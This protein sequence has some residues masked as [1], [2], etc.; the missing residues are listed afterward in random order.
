MR[1]LATTGIIFL[2]SVTGA[3]AEGLY[4]GIE[5]SVVNVE[6]EDQFGGKGFVDPSA[7]NFT[8]GYELSDKVAV[9]ALFG[10]GLSSDKVENASLD[11]GFELESV[12]GLSVVG[13]YYIEEDAKFYGNL[14]FAN[15]E[16]VDSF[17]NLADAKGIMFG[18][19][20]AYDVSEKV[21]INAGF[22]FYPEGDYPAFASDVSASGL[23]IG[24]YYKF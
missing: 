16:Y 8:L 9:E 6:L 18:F 14:G 21:G 13:S 20:F 7:L 10:Q 24:G 22:T 15:V 4:A 3:Q 1:K 19:G 12:Q 11:I 17:G 2:L 5:Y 23:D